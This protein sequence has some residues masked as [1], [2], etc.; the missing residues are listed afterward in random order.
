MVNTTCLLLG[1]LAGRLSHA[2]SQKLQPGAADPT[3]SSSSTSSSAIPSTLQLPQAQQQHPGVQPVQ[4][5]APAHTSPAAGI[6]HPAS[7]NPAAAFLQGMV[8]TLPS[9]QQQQQQQQQQLAGA[10]SWQQQDPAGQQ[11]L[12]G[13]QSIGALQQQQADPV[14]TR[15]LLQQQSDIAM[16]K[17]QNRQLRAAVCKI[18]PS[19]AV[20]RG[21]QEGGSSWSKR[22]RASGRVQGLG[23]S[24]LSDGDVWSD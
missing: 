12:Q 15:L 17:K 24:R 14:M 1:Y 22:G 5:A 6:S 16:L 8:P 9:A 7:T 23:D 10:E 2:I 20:C 21:W 18:D 3:T 11:M 4:P 13:V 19:A